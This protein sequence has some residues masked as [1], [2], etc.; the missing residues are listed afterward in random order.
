M[1]VTWQE[2]PQ[3]FYGRYTTILVHGRTLIYTNKVKIGNGARS[4]WTRSKLVPPFRGFRRVVI[5]QARCELTRVLGNTGPF[6][7]AP[8]AQEW[9]DYWNG[10]N[11]KVLTCRYGDT[12]CTP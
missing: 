10:L 9:A 12:E 2:E 8:T 1:K 5:L 6:H 7:P 4:C 11:G 3:G